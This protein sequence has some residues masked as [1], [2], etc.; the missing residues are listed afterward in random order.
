MNF[1]RGS[2]PDPTYRLDAEVRSRVLPIYDADALEYFLSAMPDETRTILLDEF[3]TSPGADR[4]SIPQFGG[5]GTED[6]AFRDAFRAVFAPL[7]RLNPET[8]GQYPFEE[9]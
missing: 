9:G 4:K 8:K 1:G 6:E 7:H 5:E 3:F 2:E